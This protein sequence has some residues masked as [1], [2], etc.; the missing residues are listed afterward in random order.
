VL[1]GSNPA[2]AEVRGS[3]IPQLL[4]QSWRRLEMRTTESDSKGTGEF[5]LALE[6]LPDELFLI[7]VVLG[8]IVGVVYGVIW[9]LG[10]VFR[11][12]WGE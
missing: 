12:F 8:A 7:P 3:M 10:A 5:F 9:L 11:S 4:H 6:L 1:V 2:F